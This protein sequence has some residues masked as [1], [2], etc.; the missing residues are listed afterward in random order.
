MHSLQLSVAANIQH[1]KIRMCTC[2]HLHTHKERGKEKER[3]ISLRSENRKSQSSSIFYKMVDSKSKRLCYVRMPKM[4]NPTW[5]HL[6][7]VL[8]NPDKTPGHAKDHGPLWHSYLQ[9]KVQG[10]LHTYF[11]ITKSRYIYLLCSL[12]LSKDFIVL[13][14]LTCGKPYFLCAKIAKIQSKERSKNC[15]RDLPPLYITF[16]CSK[17]PRLT[18]A[19]ECFWTSTAWESSQHMGSS[20][21][22]VSTPHSVS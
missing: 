18:Q 2:I 15:F 4:R 17:Q 22:T 10:L 3:T 7:P 21:I 12:V 9:E 19:F 5:I 16:Q 11:H 8:Q 20:S 13:A 6:L 14:S 1:R